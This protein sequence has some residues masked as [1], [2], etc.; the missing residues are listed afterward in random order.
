MLCLLVLYLYFCIGFI[1]HVTNFDSDIWAILDLF[2][3]TNL[4]A[5]SLKP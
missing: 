4:Q 1:L 5:T 3:N 2:Q